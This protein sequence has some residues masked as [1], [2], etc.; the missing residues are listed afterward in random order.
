ML[1]STL[2]RRSPARGPVP[3]GRGRSRKIVKAAALLASLSLLVI[4]PAKADDDASAPAEHAAPDAPPAGQA[5]ITV[6]T[7]AATD[8]QDRA[9]AHY[10]TRAAWE[11]AGY[12]NNE[13][14]YHIFIKSSDEQI[15]RCT[16]TLQ[17]S[18]IE[19]GQS[20][21]VSDR[22]LTTVFP[23]QETQVGNWLGMDQ[24]AGASYA[25]KCHSI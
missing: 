14:V 13:I 6:V 15:L 2:V 10:T 7:D 9:H 25:V 19:N 3:T 1:S 12:N 21:P 23:G 20:F 22:Q 5:P 16:T 18:Y 8:P 17:G 11:I 4:L 24:K